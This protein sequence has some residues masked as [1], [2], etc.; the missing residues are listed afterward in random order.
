MLHVCPLYA[1]TKDGIN[2]SECFYMCKEI[3]LYLVGVSMVT[4]VEEE[5]RH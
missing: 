2:Q 5:L 1:L 3:K 4:R